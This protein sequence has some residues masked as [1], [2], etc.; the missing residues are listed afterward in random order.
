MTGKPS[1]ITATVRAVGQPLFIENRLRLGNPFELYLQLLGLLEHVVAQ[2]FKIATQPFA[3]AFQTFKFRTAWLGLAWLGLAWLGSGPLLAAMME[4][5]II[6]PGNRVHNESHPSG[7]S[8]SDVTDSR[9]LIPARSGLAE[10]I[11][12]SSNIAFWPNSIITLQPFLV[13]RDC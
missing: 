6:L 7:F 12:T 9:R 10:R 4:S 2:G 13:L 3:F 11:E 5:R 1:G 8:Q